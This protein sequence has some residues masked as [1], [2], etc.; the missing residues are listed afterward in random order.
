MA[1][2]GILILIIQVC[3]A[4]HALKK[5]RGCWVFFIAFV[6]LIGCLVYF[7]VE[8]LPDIIDDSRVKD[9]VSKMKP[10]EKKSGSD[11]AESPDN[12][13]IRKVKAEFYIN[14][15]M[16]KEAIPL[17]EKCLLIS[18]NEDPSLWEGLSIAYFFSGDFRNAKVTLYKLRQMQV[19]RCPQEISLL[20]ARTLENMGESDHA[21]DEY[22]DVA[23]YY[24]GEEALRSN[25]KL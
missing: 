13:K 8:I 5:G 19:G 7:F 15:S 2:F 16:F 12:F 22:A 14:N 21:L 24:S 23:E 20:W 25:W 9:A 1:R 3:F 18:Y 10:G 17:Y 11:T 6:P 4:V